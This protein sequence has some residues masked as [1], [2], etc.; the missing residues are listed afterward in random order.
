MIYCSFYGLFSLGDF[1]SPQVMVEGGIYG[2]F[3]LSRTLQRC[4]HQSVKSTK[5]LKILQKSPHHDWA[6]KK[7]LISRTFKTP[8]SLFWEYNIF[9]KV[10]VGW[11]NTNG[12]WLIPF[13]KIRPD[14]LTLQGRG[15]LVNLV[16]IQGHWWR[17]KE[18]FM[19][20]KIKRL[21]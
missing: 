4:H 2:I 9:Q 20:G 13:R 3:S 19:I 14:K 6:A 1:E 16:L 18:V 11:K 12:Q 10:N 8:A 15:N 7:I 21:I 5:F 17:Y